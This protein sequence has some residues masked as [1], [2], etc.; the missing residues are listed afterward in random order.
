VTA[1]GAKPDGARPDGVTADGAKPDGARPDGVTADG[2]T[3]DGARSDAAAIDGPGAPDVALADGAPDQAVADL[4]QPGSDAAAGFTDAGIFPDAGGPAAAWD[5]R[6]PDVQVHQPSAVAVSGDYIY[7]GGAFEKVGGFT[8]NSIVRWSLSAKRWEPLGSGVTSPLG[9]GYGYVEAIQ[10]IGDDVYVGGRFTA[11]GGIATNHVARWNATTKTW[12]AVPGLSASG[13]IHAFVAQGTTLY[14]GGFHLT[15]TP[16]VTSTSVVA[17][18]DTQSQVWTPMQGTTHQLGSCDGSTAYVSSLAVYG[19]V[20]HAAGWICWPDP[21]IRGIARWVGNDWHPLNACPSGYVSGTTGIDV[22]RVH[23]GALYVG[24]YF[25]TA[26]DCATQVAAKNIARWDGSAFSAVGGGVDGVNASVGDLLSLGTDLYVAGD[27]TSAGGAPINGNGLARW[28][29][30]AWHALGAFVGH[31]TNWTHLAANGNTLVVAG[32]LTADTLQLDGV[33][34]WN[35][36]AWAGLRGGVELT[37]GVQ[38]VVATSGGMYVGGSFSTVG[39]IGARNVAGWNKSTGDWSPLGAGLDG[40]VTTLAVDNND[41]YAARDVVSS[42]YWSATEVLRWNGSQWVVLG[43]QFT[44]N[45]GGGYPEVRALV[46][47]GAGGLYAAG[48]FSAVGSTPVAGV[49]R[50]DGA[51]W[52]AVANLGATQ[53]VS[54]LAIHEGQIYLAINWYNG[55]SY[56]SVARVDGSTAVPL[57]PTII[58]SINSIAVDGSGVYA[59]GKVTSMGGTTVNHVARWN[60]STWHA[61]GTGLS[62]A[63]LDQCA[64][65]AIGSNGLYVAGSFTTAGG[66]PASSVAQWNGTSWFD[67]DGGVTFNGSPGRVRQ[68]AVRGAD[69]YLVGDWLN[70]AGSLSSLHVAH[71]GPP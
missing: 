5:P 44:N 32:A 34:L 30:S 48:K 3:P 39:G 22:M 40:R 4:A 42:V 23:G 7:V 53:S 1:D 13:G 21:R 56:A 59:C 46:L 19:G 49:A 28:D 58:G 10:V 37:S 12:S 36:T 6:F 14:A 26:Y 15:G 27:F 31:G 8:V 17:A 69:V 68:M 20:L 25:N 50:W 11:A 9:P 33:G 67:L 54:S 35:G 52:K 61:L 70:G 62:T 57:G 55:T 29:G 43:G 60:G 66:V 41:V 45:S 24:G 16:P 47:D 64:T 63:N 65:I 2:P 18:L 51:Q 38:A 71:W